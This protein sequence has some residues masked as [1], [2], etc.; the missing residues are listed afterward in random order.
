VKGESVK[1]V[2]EVKEV[3]PL[4]LTLSPSKRGRGKSAFALTLHSFTLHSFTPSLGMPPLEFPH[5]GKAGE[6]M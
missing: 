2:K 3:S 5:V 1:E 6:L 4:S